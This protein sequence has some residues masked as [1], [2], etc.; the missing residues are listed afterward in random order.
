MIAG[1][2][3]GPAYLASYVINGDASSLSDE[4]QARCDEW[5]EALHD[6][7]VCIVSVEG[8]QYFASMSFYSAYGPFTGDVVN[9]LTLENEV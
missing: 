5:L 8:E 6:Q 1:T 9:Y 2:L 4:E 3:I 7:G